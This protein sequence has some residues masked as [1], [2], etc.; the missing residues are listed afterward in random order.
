MKRYASYVANVQLPPRAKTSIP[1][2]SPKKPK[3]KAEVTVGA[4]EKKTVTA[5]KCESMA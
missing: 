1:Q 4:C 2:F 3:K 5:G